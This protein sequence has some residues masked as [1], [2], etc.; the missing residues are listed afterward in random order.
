MLAQS[1]WQ[2]LSNEKENGEKRLTAKLAVYK[3]W[4]KSN[5][6]RTTAHIMKITAAKRRGHYAYYGVSDK[7]K[8]CVV[9][10]IGSINCYT[11]G[12]SSW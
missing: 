8:V 9:S 11:R 10:P 7:R 2:A 4:L 6:I 12:K 5:R 3:E 1:G